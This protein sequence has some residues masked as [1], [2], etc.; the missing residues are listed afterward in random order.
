MGVKVSVIVNVHNPGSRADA[1]IRSVL[2]QS[3]PADDYEVIFVDDGSMD[4]IAERLD[5]VAAVRRNVRVLHLPHT[6]SPMRG[7]NV[8]MAAAKGDYIYLMDQGDR[9]ERGA[10]LSMHDRA[11]ETDA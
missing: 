6:G 4:G 11:V 2:E 9:L 5:T 7:R 3:M 8:G 1:C 10:L